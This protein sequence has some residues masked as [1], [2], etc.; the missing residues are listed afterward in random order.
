MSARIPSSYFRHA[1]A[2]VGLWLCLAGSGMPAHAAKPLTTLRVVVV[3]ESGQPIPRASVIVSRL[4][5]K[6]NNKVKGEPLQIKTSM[7][8]AAPLPPL[9]QGF[10]MVQV[11]SSGYQTS[12]EMIE[13][14]EPEQEH[15]VVMK[16]PRSQFSVHKDK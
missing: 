9:E 15:S 8:G 4:K 6:T 14:K 10:Y 11:I 2:A 5:G 12:G 3:D 1:V 7:Q 16:P 13:L